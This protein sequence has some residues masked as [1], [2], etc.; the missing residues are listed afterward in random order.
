MRDRA[1]MKPAVTAGRSGSSPGLK[2]GGE[3]EADAAGGVGDDDDDGVSG[4][5]H[6]STVGG[7]SR[8]VQGPVIGG[9]AI[10]GSRRLASGPGAYWKHGSSST[11]GL[12]APPPGG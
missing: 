1:E 12:P 2:P 8:R 4:D 3:A 7:A 9:P 5:V 6:D 10:P 11:S